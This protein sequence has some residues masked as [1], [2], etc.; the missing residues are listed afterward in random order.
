VDFF[1]QNVGNAVDDLSVTF[2]EAGNWPHQL[3]R[4]D[5]VCSDSKM[6]LANMGPTST[7]IVHLRVTVPKDATSEPMTFKVQA[8]SEKS[9]G[10]LTSAT[11]TVKITADDAKAGESK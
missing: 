11:I 3:C 10:A 8:V 4:L 9:E 2:T 5:G 1:T 7:G 6:T